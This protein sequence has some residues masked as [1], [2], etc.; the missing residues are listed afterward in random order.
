MKMTIEF[1]KDNSFVSIAPLY[2][3]YLSNG[4][5]DI[6]VSIG[7]EEDKNACH[8][9]HLTAQEALDFAN[10]L[11]HVAKDFKITK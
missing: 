11:I 6:C 8:T 9:V 4:E 2:T 7:D 10:E 1:S 5:L 3:Y